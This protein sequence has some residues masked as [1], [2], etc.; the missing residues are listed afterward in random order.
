MQIATLLGMKQSKSLASL[1]H[2][3]G[4]ILIGVVAGGI[5]VAFH[6]VMNLA[7]ETRADLAL[8]AVGHGIAATVAVILACGLLAGM[9]VA[10]VRLVAP[11]AEGSG[12]AAVLEA[13]RAAGHLPAFRVLWV[14]FVA[15][16]CGLASGMP[17]GREGPSV[18]IGAMTAVLLRRHGPRLVLFQRRAVSL[19]AAA[20]LAAAFNAPLSGVVFSFEL[21]RQPFTIRNCFETIL[22]C[23]VA[24]WTC[25]VFHGPILELPV[26]L[27]GF[28]DWH[29]LPVFVLVGLWTGLVVMAFQAL[30]LF[31]ARAFHRLGHHNATAIGLTAAW[32]CILGCVLF[33]W[34]EV[35]G[36]GHELFHA[37][38]A[39]EMVLVVALAALGTRILLTAASYATGAPG[40]LI[41]P[42]L[43]FGVLA[44]QCFS[45][46]FARWVTPIEPDFHA[47]CL[48]A[49]M[50][51]SI[52]G[53]FRAPL[54]ATIIA[55][56]ITGTFDCLLEISI[57]YLASHWLLDACHQPD[58]YAALGRIHRGDEPHGHRRTISARPASGP[59]GHGQV[60]IQPEDPADEPI[61]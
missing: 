48:V 61:V 57:A 27:V 36:I 40:G 28:R 41:V 31:L 53:L 29:E 23:A 1:Q 6:W 18:Q 4:T 9:S 35:L 16:F 44:G 17:L 2:Q 45:A 38:I 12:I 30:L 47:V 54:T 56:E 8:M 3:A 20:G 5:A 10:L 19:G 32:G 24:D 46:A 51:A 49:G 59:E 42:A 14:K 22:V 60:A 39:D 55:V 7:E 26:P 34:P 11:Q 37:A 43:L 13:P 21:L 15:G 50:A 52:G 33:V 58:L 25:R